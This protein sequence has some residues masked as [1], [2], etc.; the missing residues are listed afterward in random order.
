MLTISLF[1]EITFVSGK[2]MS[3]TFETGDIL[4]VKK[5]AI[6]Q[7]EDIVTAYIKELD[8]VVVKRVIGSEGDRIRI[9]ESAIY[10]NEKL[11]K[12]FIGYERQDH[13]TI[14]LTVPKG[15]VFLLGDNWKI[16]I[17][18]RDFGCVPIDAIKG[19][20]VKGIEGGS[21]S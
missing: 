10:R 13:N 15:Y 8:I 20:V 7:N 1:V 3:P 14:E 19:V 5:W 9:A 4:L 11:L 17:D 6:P 2:S 16:S 18:S 21:W 12:R